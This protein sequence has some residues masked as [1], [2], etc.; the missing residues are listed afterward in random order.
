ATSSLLKL[1][2]GVWAETTEGPTRASNTGKTQ[3]QAFM[4][5][6]WRDSLYGV[7]SRPGGRPSRAS[8]ES[9]PAQPAV[10]R[11]VARHDD[12]G[13]EARPSARLRRTP[14]SAGGGALGGHTPHD[15]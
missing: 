13:G 2:A 9:S 10:K 7:H 11:F 12:L 8:R 1:G 15:V 5:A 14:Q 4:I 3:V 6:S